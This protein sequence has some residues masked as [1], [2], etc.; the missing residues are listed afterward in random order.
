MGRTRDSNMDCQHQAASARALLEVT[1][2]QSIAPQLSYRPLETGEPD[3]L[4]PLPSARMLYRLTEPHSQPYPTKS[5]H[6]LSRDNAE[7]THPPESTYLIIEF[8]KF[9]VHLSTV[10]SS[11]LANRHLHLCYNSQSTTL[12]SCSSAISTSTRVKLSMRSVSIPKLSR[13]V[14]N[15]RSD[16]N[17]YPS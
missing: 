5:F 15:G 12:S 7:K 11:S 16:I 10:P 14:L 3:Q 17:I 9:Q 2:S 8:P 1:A 6:I 4:I 13:A